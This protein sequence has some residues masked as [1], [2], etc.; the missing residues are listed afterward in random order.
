[1]TSLFTDITP[2]LERVVGGIWKDN[3]LVFNLYAPDLEKVEYVFYAN[4]YALA[5]DVE[6][7]PRAHV[8]LDKHRFLKG[9]Q[10]QWE[11]RLAGNDASF[12]ELGYLIRVWKKE[13]GTLVSHWCLDPYAKESTGGEQWGVPMGF[14]VNEQTL[15]LQKT[16]RPR[17]NAFDGVRRLPIIRPSLPLAENRPPAPQYPE[18][19]MII[20]ECHIRG[21]TKSPTASLKNETHAG[22]YRGLVELIPYLKDLG[23][24]SVELLPLFDFDENE[25]PNVSP[26]NK[27]RLYNYWGYSTL[28]FFAPKQSYAATPQRCVEEFK[29]MV[30]AFHQADLEI[31]LDVVYNHTAE[32]NK[33]GTIDHFKYLAPHSWYLHDKHDLLSNYSGCGNTLNCSHPVV[34]QLIIESLRYWHQEMGVDGFRFDLAPILNRNHQGELTAFPHFVWELRQDPALCHVKLIAEPWDAGGGYQLGHFHYH[35]QWLEWNDRYRDTLRKAI[36]GDHGNIGAFKKALLGSPDT[37]PK[38]KSSEMASV[39]FLTAHDGMTLYDLVAYNHKH[40][41][42]NGEHN[43]DG[44]GEDYAYNCGVEGPTADPQIL[45]LRLKK[46]RTAHLLLQLSSGVPMLTAGDEMGRTQNGNNNMYCQDNPLNWINW[47][48]LK[49]YQELFKFVQTAISFRKQHLE[50]LFS[51]KSHYQ[52]YNNLGEPEDLRFHIRTLMWRVTHVKQP[53]A[54]LWV[55]LN[56]YHEPVEFRI[57]EK[58]ALHWIFDTSHPDFTH[59]KREVSAIKVDSFSVHL[60]H[61]K[62]T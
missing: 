43:R 1:M 58:D 51:G 10:W 29:E 13:K 23:V 37:F 35:A 27:E 46:I 5:E 34:K 40:N 32:Q 47:Q 17:K 9:Q 50:F 12:Q 25:N 54:S 39:N 41:K 21:M 20:Y 19:Q 61:H 24:T 14:L 57:P 31:I 4:P 2:T 3:T 48:Q 55:L 60:Y 36:R 44:H 22:T 62:L 49:D 6:F 42:A 52:W 53:K 18:N 38:L 33:K 11:T 30:D 59:Q 16:S 28:M 7:A 26:K 56:C 15:T 8:I 45:A